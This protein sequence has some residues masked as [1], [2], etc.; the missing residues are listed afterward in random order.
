LKEDPKPEQESQSNLLS[1]EDRILVALSFALFLFSLVMG[2][3]VFVDQMRVA[4]CAFV[5]TFSLVSA[6]VI[7]FKNFDNVDKDR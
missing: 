4:V 3:F 7:A 2:A 1:R 6:L 5:C